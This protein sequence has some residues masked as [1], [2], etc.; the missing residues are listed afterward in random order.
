MTE[1]INL[2]SH[3]GVLAI[4]AYKA[5]QERREAQIVHVK[6]KK[7]HPCEGYEVREDQSVRC[8]RCSACAAIRQE[9]LAHHAASFKS[10]ATKIML[11]TAIKKFI[12][13]EGSD[14]SRRV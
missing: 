2:V 4:D 10:Q 12:K 9:R 1:H 3:I 14:E 6:A 8:L 11:I 7:A 13:M 5:E